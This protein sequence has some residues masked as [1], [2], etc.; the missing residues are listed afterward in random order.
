MELE[1]FIAIGRNVEYRQIGY[2]TY[3]ENNKG[4]IST[5]W[6][7]LNHAYGPDRN[8]HPVIFET[9]VQAPD[10]EEEHM[11]RYHTLVEAVLGHQEICQMLNVNPSIN[12]NYIH[13]GSINVVAN[14]QD[15]WLSLLEE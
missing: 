3:G 9:L 11:V 14:E 4:M 15:R 2:D 10:G 5:V 6:L 1:D 7:G 12:P 13:L 8:E